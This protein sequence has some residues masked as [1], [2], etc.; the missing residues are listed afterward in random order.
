ME[1]IYIEDMKEDK[2]VEGYF[3]VKEKNVRTSRSGNLY[4]DLTLVDHTGQINAKMWNDIKEVKD[5]FSEGDAVAIKGYISLYNQKLQMTIQNIRPVREEDK[6]H[7]YDFVNLIKSSEKNLEEVW[8]SL[9]DIIETIG[10]EELKTLTQQIYT[11]WEEQLKVYPAAMK[12]HHAYRGGLLEHIHNCTK[13]AVSIGHNY[14]DYN[15]DLIKTGALL[16]DIGKIKELTPGINIDYT[17]KGNFAGHLVLGRDIL[18]ENIREIDDFP[19]ILQNKLEHILLSHHGRLEWSSPKE[20]SFPE[21]AIIY[22]SDKVDTYLEQMQNA[23]DEDRSDGDWT[24]NRNYFH[25]VLY[26]K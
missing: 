1:Q 23:I 10:T 19:E 8:N 12:L 24:G 18:I 25:R 3:G 14:P 22:Y 7:G 9:Q 4:L 13:N 2:K 26:K 5:T 16:H 11:K 17:D 15:L 20:P 21:A 6:Q